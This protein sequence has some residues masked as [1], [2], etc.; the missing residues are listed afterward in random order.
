MVLR[1]LL[2]NGFPFREDEAVYST[3]ALHF[4]SRDPLFLTMWPDK[5]PIFIW[6]LAAIFALAGPSEFS[7][8]WLNVGVSVLTI[9]ILTVIAHRLWGWQRASW[10]TVLVALNPLAISFASTAYIDPLLVLA[11]TTALY[12]AISEKPL[13]SGIW[14]GVAVMT[15][16]QGLLYIPLIAVIPF[17]ISFCS[18]D[19]G[20]QQTSLSNTC[21]RILTGASLVVVPLLVGDS[22]RWAVAPSPWDLSM[23]NYGAITLLSLDAWFWR[24]REWADQLWYLVGG[25]LPLLVI[26]VGTLG[27]SALKRKRDSNSCSD[28]IRRENQEKWIGLVIAVW[29]LGFVGLHVAF[30]VEIW[31]RYLLPLTPVTAMAIGGVIDKLQRRISIGKPLLLL[32]VILLFGPP[33]LAASR[34]Y[35][36]IGGDHGALSGLHEALHWT[37]REAGGKSIIIYHRDL[38]PQL[39]FYLSD[40][41]HNQEIDLR[42]YPHYVYLADNATKVPHKRK[43]LIQPAWATSSDLPFH[44]TWRQVQIV[45]RARFDQ[46]IVS[47]LYHSQSHDCS[48]CVCRLPLISQFP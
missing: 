23:R 13:W 14:L 44:S 37:K 39:R 3:W 28:V 33:A 36:P 38:G 21:G 4:L 10:V 46:M 24:A 40:N 20:R 25:N 12:C 17:V 48:W 15:K 30:S 8:R 26:A 27:L 5:P 41:L 22:L 42:W 7:A 9:P 31:D 34:G 47:E 29:A 19:S 18:V 6:L 11:G 43:F 16:Q 32:A 45:E 35:M 2:I 1:V